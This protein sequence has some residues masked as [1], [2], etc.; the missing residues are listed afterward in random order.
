MLGD[1]MKREY[2]STPEEAFE[3]SI[4]GAYFEREFRQ[5]REKRQITA[6]P[7]VPGVPVDTCWDLGMNDTTA[8]WFVQLVGREQRIVDYHEASGEGLAHYAKVLDE[9]GREN[10]WRADPAED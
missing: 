8:I 3:Q 2:P 4:K 7:V 1:D 5:L 10:E 6:V 9:K